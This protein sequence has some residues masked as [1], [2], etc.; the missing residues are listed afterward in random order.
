MVEELPGMTQAAN[1]E[2]SS[3]D[4]GSGTLRQDMATAESARIEIHRNLWRNLRDMICKVD[5][6]N[7]TVN[8]RY[9]N[10]PG[11]PERFFNVR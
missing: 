8:S 9:K 6:I 3:G 4:G 5:K 1:R 2:V 10:R 11:F 7:A